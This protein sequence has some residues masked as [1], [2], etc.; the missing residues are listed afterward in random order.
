MLQ[1]QYQMLT[2][3]PENA[4][5]MYFYSSSSENN[6]NIHMTRAVFVMLVLEI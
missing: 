3:E 2:F 1:P 4:G 6:K 5:G